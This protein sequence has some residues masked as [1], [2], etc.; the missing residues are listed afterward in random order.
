M[1]LESQRIVTFL[2]VPY[3]KIEPLSVIQGVKVKIQVQVVLKLM[4]LLNFSQIS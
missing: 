3:G 2:D 4:N 1:K